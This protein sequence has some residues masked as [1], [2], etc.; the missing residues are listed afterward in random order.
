MQRN[1]FSMRKSNINMD[2][3]CR[4]WQNSSDH[5]IS[6]KVKLSFKFLFLQWI[7]HNYTHIKSFLH[8]FCKFLAVGRKDKNA[9]IS[10]KDLD[11]QLNEQ[12]LSM[13]SCRQLCKHQFLLRRAWSCHF[14]SGKIS[15]C[16][17]WQIC[18]KANSFIEIFPLKHY[19]QNQVLFC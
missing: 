11:V 2:F 18:L 4:R 16:L 13:Q 1:A 10:Q 9:V 19:D 6:T 7:E 15:I 5:F 17:H 12:E 14:Y 8:S 3:Y